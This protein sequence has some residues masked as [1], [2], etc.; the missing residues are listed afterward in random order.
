M[1]PVT[2]HELATADNLHHFHFIPRP[3]HR[4]LVLRAL[5]DPEIVL[6]RDEARIDAKT[7]EKGTDRHGTGDFVRF[8]VE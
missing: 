5:D 2:A 6:D 7:C 4:L 1:Q 3:H 8:A